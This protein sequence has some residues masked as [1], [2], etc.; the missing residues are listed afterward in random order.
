MIKLRQH[1]I[2]EVTDAA[3]ELPVETTL[4]TMRA[5]GSLA[6]D[7][8]RERI[9]EAGMTVEACDVDF[10]LRWLPDETHDGCKH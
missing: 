6:V 1:H 5:L 8:L 2:L 3:S 4:A 10:A 9:V 7:R